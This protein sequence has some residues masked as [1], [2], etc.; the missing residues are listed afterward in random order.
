[1]AIG[2]PR[3]SSS[4]VGINGDQTDNSTFD[5]YQST[6]AGAAYLFHRDLSG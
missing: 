1:M 6:Y 4:A 3:E 5:D 2:A